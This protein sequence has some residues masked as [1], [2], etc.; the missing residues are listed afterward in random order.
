M[1][2]EKNKVNKSII[3]KALSQVSLFSGLSRYTLEKLSDLAG[4]AHYGKGKEIIKEGEKGDRVFIIASGKVKVIKRIPPAGEMV[5][6]I[7]GP[8]EVIGEM[9]L[10]DG[11]PRSADVVA[12]ED[13][14][15]FYITAELFLHFIRTNAEIS[16]KMMQTLSLRLREANDKT[17]FL[18]SIIIRNLDK[19]FQ[20]EEQYASLLPAGGT[21]APNDYAGGKEEDG[22]NQD[23]WFL[24]KAF[25]CPLCGKDT[26]SLV[27]KSKYIQVDNIDADMCVYYRLANPD[28]YQVIV[29]H[30][31]GF[32]FTE[33]SPR[34]VAPNYAQS[35]KQH[36]FSVRPGNFSGLRTMDEAIDS[37]ILGITCQTLVRARSSLLGR[38]HLRLS[39]LYRQKGLLDQ[40]MYY[41]N[42]ALEN[43]E[44]AVTQERFSNPR[45]EL[46]L[47]Y[48]IGELYFKL[49]S[50]PQAVQ[51]FS[52]VTRHPERQSNPYIVNRAR[53]RWQEIKLEG[54]R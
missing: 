44:K 22:Q 1:Y 26:P 51:W 31:C 29:C 16:L 40:E 23:T 30:R 46:Y 20:D 12:E 14:I 48:L 42:G 2:L 50:L 41:L 32:A 54:A 5:L 3:I 13:V 18:E 38:L 28:F 43:F 10:I 53:N 52:N 27:V 24:E 25:T 19:Q 15:L 4:V 37:Y 45:N 47:I 6:R 9:S 11:L 17:T 36:L 39:C 34:A 7:V 49:G 8:C 21:Q 35:I 33:D